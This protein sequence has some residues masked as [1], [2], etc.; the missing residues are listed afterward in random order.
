MMKHYS[1]PHVVKNYKDKFQCVK[2]FE[3]HSKEIR[4]LFKLKVLFD[5]L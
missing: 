2:G 1:V 4:I 5:M 3:F